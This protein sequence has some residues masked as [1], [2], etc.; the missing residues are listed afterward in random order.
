MQL[1]VWNVVDNTSVTLPKIIC[2]HSHSFQV[3]VVPIQWSS[4][5]QILITEY[6]AYKKK[7]FHLAQGVTGK[8]DRDFSG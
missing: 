2:E 8:T 4:Y 5:L 1:V 7:L 6:L 3:K